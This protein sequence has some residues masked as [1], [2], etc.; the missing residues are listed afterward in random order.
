[1][2]MT[3]LEPETA[4][5]LDDAELPIQVYS[6]TSIEGV[7]GQTRVHTFHG[8]KSG[9]DHNAVHG[10]L[11]FARLANGTLLRDCLRADVLEALWAYYHLPITAHRGEGVAEATYVTNALELGEGTEPEFIP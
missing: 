2:T 6:F 11:H 8:A 7:V 1:M 4:A 5:L 10:V 9:E 3:T